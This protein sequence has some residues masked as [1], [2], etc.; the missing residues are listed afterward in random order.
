[1]SNP[2]NTIKVI[3]KNYDQFSKNPIEGI[4]IGFNEDNIF[5]WDVVIIGSNDSF[6]ESSVFNA[7]IEFP[8]DYPLNPPTF[9]FK[10]KIFHPNIY[11]DGR[12][13]ISILHP[14]GNDEFGYEKAEERWRPV[15]TFSSIILSIISLL[16]DPNDESPANI[17]A[18]KIWREDKKEFQR[19]VN[20][21]RKNSE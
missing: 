2:I 15:H 11:E 1:M 8:K 19:I 7:E 17:N 9:V 14:P 3:K 4:S 13:C 10:T 21:Y 18:A 20:Q 5:K 16:N 6:Y 12:V